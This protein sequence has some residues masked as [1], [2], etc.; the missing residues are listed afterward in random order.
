MGEIAIQQASVFGAVFNWYSK[1][2]DF[3][4]VIMNHHYLTIMS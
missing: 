4:I 1:L 2:F 3:K